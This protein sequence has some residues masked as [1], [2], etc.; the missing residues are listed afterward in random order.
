VCSHWPVRQWHGQLPATHHQMPSSRGSRL[1]PPKAVPRLRPSVRQLQCVH[2][3]Q[4]DAQ[5]KQRATPINARRQRQGGGPVPQRPSRQERGWV[6]R[7]AQSGADV[8]APLPSL[9]RPVLTE[10]TLCHDC[11]CQE[12]LGVATARQVARQL[13]RRTQR[14]EHVD[15]HHHLEWRDQGRN[16]C[17]PGTTSGT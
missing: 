8:S 6:L 2:W 10:I 16:G 5:R 12:M 4:V 13:P 11:S 14:S 1:E 3:R 15:V 9:A 7:R 17:V